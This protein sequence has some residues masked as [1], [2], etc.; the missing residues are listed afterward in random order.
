MSDRLRTNPTD[1]DSSEE[2]LKGAKEFGF[3]LSEEQISKFLIHNSMIAVKNHR[4][5]LTRVTSWKDAQVLHVLDSLSVF[6][7]I[8]NIVLKNNEILDLG[9][10]AGFPGIPLAIM[11]PEVHFTLLDSRRKKVDF[12][13]SVICKLDLNNVELV[14]GRAEELAHQKSLRGAF[15]LV[16]SRAVAPLRTLIELSAPFLK[17]NGILVA[18]KSEKIREELIDADNAIQTFGLNIESLHF[19]QKFKFMPP[20]RAILLMEN[21]KLSPDE[22]PRRPGIPSKKPL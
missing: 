18:Q 4:M 11:L 19:F 10:G 15:D 6:S 21:I 5:N 14:V 2:L 22:F 7:V 20:G 8:K 16:T 13:K 3:F 1:L 17:A 12:L 9:T